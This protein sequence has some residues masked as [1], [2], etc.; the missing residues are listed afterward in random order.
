MKNEK[1][2]MK[3]MSIR[4]SEEDHLSLKIELVRNQISLQDYIYG[5]LLKDG[6]IKKETNS[7]E[8]KN[9]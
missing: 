8:K 2:K 9:I 6:K 5:L 1:K 3:N 4:L 7:H